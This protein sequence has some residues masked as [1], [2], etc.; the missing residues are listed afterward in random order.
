MEYAVS[1]EGGRRRFFLKLEPGEEL[2]S[3]LSTFAKRMRISGASLTAIGAVKD[4]ELGWFDIEAKTYLTRIFP[5]VLELLSLNGNIA[6]SDEGILVHLHATAAGKDLTPVGGHVCASTCAVT[7]EAFVQETVFDLERIQ[8][9]RFN[10]C[11][12]HLPKHCE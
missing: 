11:L 10:L 12:L 9:D 7:I 1:G 6:S 8:D 2:L 5:D 4:T 3:T